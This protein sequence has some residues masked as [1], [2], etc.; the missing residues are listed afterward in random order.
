MADF[1]FTIDAISNT[2][3]YKLQRGAVLVPLFGLLRNP[4][5]I[6]RA[7]QKLGVWRRAYLG[8][9][10][11]AEW[12]ALKR[13]GKMGF[14]RNCPPAFGYVQP[15]ARP[16]H[17]R[18]WCP[19][20]YAREVWELR[21][22]IA[23]VIRGLYDSQDYVLAERRH[24][25]YRPPMKNEHGE[26]DEHSHLHELLFKMNTPWPG[27]YK[28]SQAVG[29]HFQTTIVPDPAEGWLI[30]NRQLYLLHAG[31]TLPPSLSQRTVGRIR[32][33]PISM[34]NLDKMLTRLCSYPT[35]LLRGDHQK[36]AMLL[37]ARSL[38]RPRLAASYGYFRT[39]RRYG[40]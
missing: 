10:K 22:H 32:Y 35:Q 37:N 33:L 11:S 4:D 26:S 3:E 28:E 23:G 21:E 27:V 25:Y 7:T 20:C 15:D 31:Q 34:N 14:A 8:H 29:A 16:C 2:N 9:F 19:F 5:E 38:M 1:D 24:R 17:L 18:W 6:A 30:I 13:F 12:A 39:T 40:D 36:V